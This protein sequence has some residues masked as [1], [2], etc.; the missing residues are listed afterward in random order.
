MGKY[1]SKHIPGNPVIVV[2]NMPGA[3]SMKVANFLYNAAP[4]DGTTLDVFASSTALEP[5]FGNKKAQYGPRKFAWIG[6]MHQDTASCAIWNGG[7]QNI[8]TADDLVKAKREVT[9][10]STS[11]AAIT[12]QHAL[13]LK[14]YHGAPIKVI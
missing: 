13:V 5:L 7:G 1:L 4:K 8:R 14:N 6:S 11:P 9:F 10:G 3:G 2:Q 12:S